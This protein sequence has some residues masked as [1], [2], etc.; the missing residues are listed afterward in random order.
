MGKN[1]TPLGFLS[2]VVFVFYPYFSPKGFKSNGFVT[3]MDNAV[4]MKYR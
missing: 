2:G 4:G 3:K 1:I